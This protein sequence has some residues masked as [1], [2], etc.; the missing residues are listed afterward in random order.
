MEAKKQLETQ[1]ALHQKTKDLLKT[2]EQ[3]VS[4]LKL[5]LGQSEA[6][7][8]TP[9]QGRGAGRAPV[10]GEELNCRVGGRYRERDREIWAVKVGFHLIC[11]LLP[12]PRSCITVCPC[13]CV[14][15]C[16]Y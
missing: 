1:N 13:V 2:T 7:A 9:G 3:Q 15:V 12:Y 4:A 5:Q 16:A 8:Q 14:C 10:R 6:S 11:A